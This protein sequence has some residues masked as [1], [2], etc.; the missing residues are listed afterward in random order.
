MARIVYFD[1]SVFIELAK[2]KSS[3]AK[4]LRGLLK[5]LEE[6]KA[7]IYTSI[8][9]VQEMSVAV[10]RR[11]AKSKD[12]YG[13]IHQ[14]ARIYAVN[15]DVALTAAHREAELKD[16]AEKQQ[17]GGKP[18]EDQRIE[19]ICENRKRRWDCFHI[20]TA[21]TIGCT[22]MYST[23]GKLQDR[24]KQLGIHDLK[25]VAPRPTPRSVAGPLFGNG[26]G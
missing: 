25:I 4:E 22:V 21:Q 1:T 16:I 26:A 6:E 12:T 5:E 14:L 2:P 9:T 20:A 15:K 10:Y 17:T 3:I 8:I 23:D 18:T 11:G 24:P 13:D 7:R 19:T